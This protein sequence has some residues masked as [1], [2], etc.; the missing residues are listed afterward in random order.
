MM[1][2]PYFSKLFEIYQIRSIATHLFNRLVFLVQ[3]QRVKL[4]EAA[5]G[6]N[7]HAS[8]PNLNLTCQVSNMS[9]APTRALQSNATRGNMLHR[10]LNDIELS[11]PY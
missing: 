4:S 2:L 5:Q 9:F 3:L 11:H 6:W 1:F 10:P 7:A 8:E